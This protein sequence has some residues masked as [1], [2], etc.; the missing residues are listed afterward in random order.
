MLFPTPY[1]VPEKKAKKK[2]KGTRSGLRH[3]G[4]SDVTSE[5]AEARSSAKDDEEEEEEEEIHSP[6]QEKKR[7]GRPPRIRRPWRPRKGKLPFRTAP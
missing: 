5:D 3:K 7:K 2:A 6:L 4:T 1:E